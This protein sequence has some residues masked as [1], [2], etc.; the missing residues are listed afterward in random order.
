MTCHL[1]RALL[2][3]SLLLAPPLLAGSPPQCETASSHK[4]LSFDAIGN[5]EL[6]RVFC[7]ERETLQKVV[8][9]IV[10]LAVKRISAEE[11]PRIVDG[12]G[13]YTLVDLG[14][15]SSQAFQSAL[16]QATAEYLN[17][18][19]GADL[20]RRIAPLLTNGVSNLV[21]SDDVIVSGVPLPSTHRPRAVVPE[22]GTYSTNDP[23]SR[24]QHGLRLSKFVQAWETQKGSTEVTVAIIDSGVDSSQTDFQHERVVGERSFCSEC[25]P[26]PRPWRDT[27]GHGTALAGVL[28]ADTSNR[29]RVA[30]TNWHLRM[31]PLKFLQDDNRGRAIDAADAVC[32]AAM[33]R[34]SLILAAWGTKECQST[35]LKNAIGYAREK[36]VLFVTAAGNE[37]LDLKQ[38]G[39]SFYPASYSPELEN[40]VVVGAT[41]FDG[42]KMGYSSF[43]DEVVHLGAPGVRTPVLGPERTRPVWA[44][45]GTSVATAY[46]AGAAALVYAE[47]LETKGSQP[48][49]QDVKNCLLEGSENQDD[50]NWSHGR[51]DAAE[52]VRLVEDGCPP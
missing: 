48:S 44:A 3:G 34:V 25:R 15:V 10:A 32:Y 50:P 22:I 8:E 6:L 17:L 20:S 45:S 23:L 36:N 14:G 16:Q 49:F 26:F 29:F 51:L 42:K 7:E 52:A 37:N 11:K 30:G 12:P 5:P 9:A 38:S 41:G 40:M 4:V 13:G 35:P 47:W 18:S 33:N 24:E 27:T 2:C 43:G 19:D 39:N 31:M 1:L 46:V 21:L 28:G